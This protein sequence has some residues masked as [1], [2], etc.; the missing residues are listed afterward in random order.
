MLINIYFYSFINTR[1]YS[2]IL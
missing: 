2:W 1:R